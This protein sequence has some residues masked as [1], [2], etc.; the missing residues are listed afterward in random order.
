MTELATP[1]APEKGGET[2]EDMF[3]RL[4]THGK[5]NCVTHL[6]TN[7]TIDEAINRIAT[8]EGMYKIYWMLS[9]KAQNADQETDHKKTL[10]KKV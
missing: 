9:Q 1:N 8:L 4:P 7:E 3:K 10:T 6:L 5:P 2:I